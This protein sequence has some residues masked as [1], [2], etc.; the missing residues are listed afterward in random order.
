LGNISACAYEDVVV[1]LLLLLQE[2]CRPPNAA[3]GGQQQDAGL[4]ATHGAG[5]DDA[6]GPGSLFSALDE[7]TQS[8][9]RPFLTT[10]FS[11]HP[12]RPEPPGVFVLLLGITGCALRDLHGAL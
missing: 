12:R 2:L 3:R 5:S 4:V 1:T 10:R 9:V 11:V 6:A 8:M 7:N